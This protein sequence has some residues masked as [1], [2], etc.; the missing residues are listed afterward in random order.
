MATTIGPVT[1]KTHIQHCMM[2]DLTIGSTTYY[3]SG[4]YKTITYDGNDYTELGSFL[5][6]SEIAEDIKATN[7]DIN[8]SLSG[9]PSDQDYMSLILSSKIK[10]GVVKIH[11]AFFN[12]DMTVDSANIFQRYNGIITNFSIA[13]NTN[14]LRGENT[15]S[16]TVTCAS[17]NTILENKV[18]GQR[19]NLTDR[20]KYFAS[21]NTF[22]RVS[23]L[24]NVQFDFGKEYNRGA[25]AGGGYGG[26]YGDGGFGGFGGGGFGGF[27]FIGHM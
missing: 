9:I 27:G 25:G 22:N 13:E 5:G 10:G 17:I 19:T 12:D 7:G 8:L 2:V 18:A 15:N 21:D 4:A 24:H 1:D 23:D 11:R 6:V 14:I 26:G 3:L 20:Q 16:V